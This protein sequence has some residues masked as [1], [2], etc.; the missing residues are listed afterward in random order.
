MAFNIVQQSDGGTLI[1]ADEGSGSATTGYVKVQFAPL[2]FA[3]I[4]RGTTDTDRTYIALTRSDGTKMYLYVD[5]GTTLT[6]STTHP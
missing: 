6:V 2:V 5:T 1:K 4:G 3:E